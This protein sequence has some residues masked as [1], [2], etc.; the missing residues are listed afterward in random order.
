MPYYDC[1]IKTVLKLSDFAT[2]FIPQ[3]EVTFTFDRHRETQYNATILY[4]WITAS[5]PRIVDSITFGNRNEPGIQAADLWAREL[6]KRCDSHL[7]NDRGHPR[8]QWNCLAATKR[9]QFHFTLGRELMQ[10]LNE[11]PILAGFNHSDYEQWRTRN[12]LVDNLSNR[13]RYVSQIDLA[14]KTN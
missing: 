2:H 7:F 3:D 5:K 8:P 14:D 10:I 4:D 1:F 9:F 13:F 11:E 6:M 12:H